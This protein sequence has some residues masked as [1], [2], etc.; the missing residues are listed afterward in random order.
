LQHHGWQLG[1]WIKGVV[2]RTEGLE[3]STVGLEVR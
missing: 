2:V 1:S 3:P